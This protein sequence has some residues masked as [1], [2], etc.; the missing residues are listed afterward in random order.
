MPAEVSRRGFLFYLTRGSFGAAAL[1][2]SAGCGSIL[3]P[4]RIGQRSGPLDWRVVAMDGAGMLLFFIPGLIAFAVDFYNGTIFLPPGHYSE[5]SA[6]A[7]A[8]LVAV[9]VPPEALDQSRI[10]RVVSEHLGQP[11][12][13]TSGGY[14]TRPLPNVEEFWP[15]MGRLREDVQS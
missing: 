13:L 2:A 8:D 5:Y 15:Q 6:G 7:R 11:I 12:A 3:Y 9:E 4:E 10:E 14:H 1:A